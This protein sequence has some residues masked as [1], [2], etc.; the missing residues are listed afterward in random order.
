MVKYCEN[1]GAEISDE[2]LFCPQCKSYV[3]RYKKEK[4]S[5]LKWVLIGVALIILIIAAGIF[6]SNTASKTSTTLTMYSSSNLGTGHYKVLLADSANNPLVD[7]YIT[8]E[9]ENSTY[10]L[11]TNSQGVASI[12]LTVKKGSHEINAKFM[13]DDSY[14]ESHTSDIVIM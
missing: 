14:G 12:N 7:K 9:F 5:N 11:K 3:K 10:T 4:T 8:V 2:S 1:C 13:G 6:F